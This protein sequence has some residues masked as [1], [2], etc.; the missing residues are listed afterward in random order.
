MHNPYVLNYVL[1]LQTVAI[2]NCVDMDFGLLRTI[3]TE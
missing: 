3:Q 1:Q 2:Y